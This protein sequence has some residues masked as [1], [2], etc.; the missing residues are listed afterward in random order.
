[1][2]QV[3]ID[4]A[5]LALPPCTFEPIKRKV[6]AIAL[7]DRCPAVVLQAIISRDPGMAFLILSRANFNLRNNNDGFLGIAASIN[8][9]GVPVMVA[10]LDELTAIPEHLVKP[11]SGFWLSA[12]AASTMARLIVNRCGARLFPDSLSREFAIL[13]GLFYDLGNLT[14]L[15][16]F[17]EQYA[18]AA[19]R[20]LAGEPD[21][22]L[23][24]SEELGVGPASLGYRY[25]TMWGLPKPIC[26]GI[27]QQFLMPQEKEDPSPMEAII[28]LTRNLSC[29][30]GYPSGVDHFVA[31]INHR[32]LD[33]LGIKFAD[34]CTLVNDFFHEM[35]QLESYEL[36][37]SE[38]TR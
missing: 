29:A 13:C 3:V 11:L 12:G 6:Q 21:F 5:L 18:K 19:S 15:R 31:D 35:R 9:L 10:L 7:D 1:L 28:G 8:N 37:T 36:T 16:I 33:V 24:L 34:C 26:D 20:L 14:A 32:W 2:S 4:N 17:G 22:S 23:L 27:A 38:H 25:A 30:C